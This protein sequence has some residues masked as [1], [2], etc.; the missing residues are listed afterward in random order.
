MAVV[1]IA[2]P[3]GGTGKTTTSLVLG[4]TLAQQG[5]SVAMLDCDKNQPLARW[6]TGSSRT[7]ARVI[8]DVRDETIVAVIE[9]EARQ[10]QFVFVDL[11]G[12]PNRMT[13]RAFSRA[14]L[15][16]LP[17]QGMPEDAEM[18]TKAIAL[19]R[20][21]EEAFR[22]QIPYRVLLT[23]TNAA[24][25]P[26]LERLITD[27]IRRANIPVFRTELNQRVAYPHMF[28]DRLTLWEMNEAA[29]TG[30]AAAQRNALELAGE[31]VDIIASLSAREAAE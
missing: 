9:R 16:V 8:E 19:V 31:L 1:V 6:R 22:R 5:A 18:A 17:L 7:Q 11:E 28:L 3:K 10:N 30:L 15:I 26:R 13:S 27:E 14:D 20:E 21:E 29:V 24:V 25:K 4:T 23:R 2:N 12:T